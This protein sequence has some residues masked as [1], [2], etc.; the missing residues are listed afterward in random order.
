MNT[1][2]R[3]TTLLF[4]HYLKHLMH[5]QIPSC[6]TN[7]TFDN[8]HLCNCSYSI[9]AVSKELKNMNICIY[10]FTRTM[11]RTGGVRHSC[12]IKCTDL[13]D[14][15]KVH[16]FASLMAAKRAMFEWH[17]R[18]VGHSLLKKYAQMNHEA[19]GYKWEIVGSN[20]YE[21]EQFKSEDGVVFTFRDCV[22]SIFNGTKVRITNEN[23]RRVS[24]FDVIRIV[25][26]THNPHAAFQRL[27][28]AN[29]EVISRTE[30]I[31]FDGHGQRE[32]P[33]TDAEGIIY[34]INLLPGKRAT[35][36]RKSAV[37]V[38]VR[39]LAGDQSLHDEVDENA[40]LQAALPQEHPM[41]MMNEKVYANPRSS[42]F[43]IRSPRLQGK[44][45]SN[46]Y[47]AYVVYLLEFEYNEKNYIKIGWSYDFKKRITTHFKELPGCKVYSIVTVRDAAT[48][49]AKLKDDFRAYNEH[50][51]ISGKTKTELFIG[52]PI[53]EVEERLFELCDTYCNDSIID[54]EL[55]TMKAKMA[56]EL[57]LKE[58]E[59]ALKEKEIELEKT[60]TELDIRKLELELEVLKLKTQATI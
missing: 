55:D 14:P 52:I 31:S 36:F 34:I 47:N 11:S 33:V 4:R 44:Y 1:A 42:K 3:Y 48:I 13:S 54:K 10:T 45:I 5:A 21:S 16:E 20:A 15:S 51:V 8:T 23:P 40:E 32:T 58:K 26:E 49:E 46:F 9:C 25:T 24:V 41:Q 30:N 18:N 56:H 53:E 28:N 43:L 22:E 17:Q 57:A 12:A 2:T 6:K 19:Y 39:Y 29:E 59:I 27:C 50:L 37:Q 7:Y 35:L 60:K 38:L